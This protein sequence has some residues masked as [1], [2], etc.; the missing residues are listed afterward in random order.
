MYE[1]VIDTV[2]VPTKEHSVGTELWN[3]RP[4]FKSCFYCLSSL[5]P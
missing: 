4:G 3:E 2:G 5:V 1:N